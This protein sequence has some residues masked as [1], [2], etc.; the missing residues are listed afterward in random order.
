MPY[1]SYCK[2]KIVSS[3]HSIDE[4][5]LH[6]IFTLTENNG[7]Y[8]ECFHVEIGIFANKNELI[9]KNLNVDFMDVLWC[10][11]YCHFI[12]I[13][14]IIII[15]SALFFV[16]WQYT[17]NGLE[18]ESKLFNYYSLSILLCTGSIYLCGF[19]ACFFILYQ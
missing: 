18:L 11:T 12:I 9:C 7:Q 13:I 5:K 8:T 10:L 17:N 16:I 6:R 19:L 2:Q 4:P 15:I 14:I 3:R 1:L